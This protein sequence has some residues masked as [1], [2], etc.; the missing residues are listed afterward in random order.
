MDTLPREPGLA[1]R[2]A[3]G[4]IIRRRRGFINLSVRGSRIPVYNA[5]TITELDE[6]QLEYEVLS[7]LPNVK[8]GASLRTLIET[9][10]VQV[11]ET[12]Q[13]CCICQYQCLKGEITRELP[14]HHNFHIDCIDKWL[15]DSTRCPLC[16]S[17]LIRSRNIGSTSELA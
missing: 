8:I 9:T 14:C 7:E 5:G 10:R 2:L 6:N 15:C 16:T 3:Y 4:D 17:T 12:E 1:R 11:A 13:F